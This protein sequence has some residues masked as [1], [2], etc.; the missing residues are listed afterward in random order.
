MR[1]A[2]LRTVVTIAALL[3]S[4][5]CLGQA[6]AAAPAAPAPAPS[7]A[8]L[9][10]HGDN[11]PPAPQQDNGETYWPQVA[12]SDG[13]IYTLYTPQ[14]QSLVG[15]NATARAAFRMTKAGGQ[16]RY[17]ALFFGATVDNDLAAGLVQVS[18]I[19]IQR[20]QM[21][22]TQDA[23]AVQGVLQQMLA[24]ASFTVQRSVVL[25]NMEVAA[26]NGT[27]TVANDVPAIQVVDQP[28]VLLLLDGAPVL[29]S[30]GAGVGIAQNTPS[31]LAWDSGS[32]TWF[33][34]VGTSGWLHASDFDGPYSAGT[35]PTPDVAKAIEAALP[36]RNAQASRTPSPAK[37]PNVVVSTTPLCL[38]SINGPANLT[39]V[40]GGLL[41]V[42]NANCD[43]FTTSADNAWWLLVSGRWFRSMDLMNGPWSYV[44]PAAL[45]A[46]FAQ[47][48]PK[49][50]WGNVLAAVPGTA[51]ANDA[52]YQ[53]AV[54]HVATLV[55]AKA[56]PAVTLVGDIA[57]FAPIAGT[58]LTWATNASCP[59]IGCGGAFYLC[60]DGA[61]FT[62]P[63]ANGPWS[64]CDTLPD[65]I[66][67]IP[68]SSPLY[69]V[70][71]VQV[72]GSTADTVT[73]GFTAGYMN[74][75]ANGGIASYGSGAAPASVTALGNAP[76]GSEPSSDAPQWGDYVGTPITYGCW[77]NFGYAGW[78][79]EV[80]PGWG[81]C[82][83]QCAPEWACGGWWG[84]GRSFGVRWALGMGWAGAWHWGYHP[85]GWR[86]T[87]G[88]WAN[89]WGGA[90]RRTWAAALQSCNRAAAAGDAARIATAPAAGAKASGWMHAGGVQDDVQATR[91]GGVVQ[92]RNGQP[93]ARTAGGWARA[94]D[95]QAAGGAA[96]TDAAQAAAGNA[97]V[98]FQER[99]ASTAATANARATTMDDFRPDPNHNFDGSP[100]GAFARGET[101]YAD[102]SE[103]LQPGNAGQPASAYSRGGA[104][105]GAGFD[106]RDGYG[107]AP[108]PQQQAG[109]GQ[110]GY[111]QGYQGWT[112]GQRGYGQSSGYTGARGVT[113]P[114]DDGYSNYE[115][116]GYSN[117]EGGGYAGAGGGDTYSNYEHGGGGVSGY[118][119][120]LLN[121]TSGPARSGYTG[122]GGSLNFGMFG[123]GMTGGMNPH[124]NWM[125]MWPGGWGGYGYGG[126][127][128]GGYYGRNANGAMR[129]N[130]VRR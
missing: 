97:A 8:P 70:T 15:T 34:R 19:Q 12:V 96:P 42:S 40:A 61:W 91:D 3:A 48:D 83:L 124:V 120:G 92:Q 16:R 39:Q 100:R 86:G 84:P 74:S 88:W 65:A 94:S 37:L 90:Y 122:G 6:P 53:Q 73:F 47:I 126:G 30:V 66:A 21:S 112:N 95:A 36:A 2:P 24:G 119:G 93:Y 104:W 57:K 107:S 18:G 41:A 103:G 71:F 14:F 28:S 5:A 44:K 55:R 82:A 102:R 58:Q 4:A 64:L 27:V 128:Y 110:G 35:A 62:A 10:E 109:G 77:T 129:V 22:D 67:A 113:Q 116:G 54:P 118:T 127:C 105:N 81:E 60:Q 101:N 25:A 78:N 114:V 69:G 125:G 43:L 56:V 52:L 51:A 111:A 63:A 87:D 26:T 17:G 32:K 45:P 79:L 130:N 75:F 11:Q 106:R 117:Y 46:A 23:A 85:W 49:G 121:N 108:M 38:V 68:P 1:P 13:T 31:L 50:T 33:T 20:V 123:Y 76:D 29:R 115:G 99:D 98:G 80:F 59:L 72:M 7:H 89:H 9:F